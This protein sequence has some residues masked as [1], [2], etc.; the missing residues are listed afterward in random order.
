[1]N[2]LELAFRNLKR[3]PAR[4]IL[5]ALGV[6]LA[7]GSFITLYGLSRS[8][9]ENVQQSFEERGTDLT[10]RRRGIAEPFGG[11]MPQSIIPE[12][13]KIPGIAAVSGQLLSFAAT[14]N[15]DHVIA[16]GWAADSFYW[17]TVP[18]LEG[19]LPE[20]DERKV[21]LVGKD[22]ARTLDKHVGDDIT[23]LGDKFR[24]VGITDYASII[25][26]NAVIVGLA[27]LQ[28]IT[29][30]TG[31]VTFI[32][33]KLAHPGSADEADRVARAIEALGQ[34]SVTKSEGVLSNDSLI[35]LLSAVSTSM[36]WVALLMGVL[37]V[38]NTLLMAVLERTREIGILSAIGWSKQ[39]IMGALVIEGF[40]LS[41]LGSAVGIAIGIAGSHLLSAIPAIGR[42]IAVRP[43]PGLIAATALAAIVLGIL[44]SFYPAFVATRQ[45]P[46][47]A[48]ERA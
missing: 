28:E 44:G 41:A 31:A 23:L 8:V 33:I 17:P 48:L 37:M 24:V 7:V 4:S 39:R 45:S 15:D 34:L 2:H 1:V 29:F 30:R 22:I 40:I 36:A 13:A 19:R 42:Y 9:Q 5:T 14:D 3:R 10:V 11:T 47:A 27:D 6:A 32:S 38:L 26:R 20:R 35:G 18:L 25:N 46:A 21:A 12:I 43:T 16:F